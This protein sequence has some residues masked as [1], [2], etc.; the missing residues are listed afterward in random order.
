[1]RP[2]VFNSSLALGPGRLNPESRRGIREHPTVP[3]SHNTQIL[4]THIQD[5]VYKQFD[6]RSVAYDY[7]YN[8][9]GDNDLLCIMR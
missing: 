1:M 3:T 9:T 7:Y 4:T 2:S 8:L 5:Y 6:G